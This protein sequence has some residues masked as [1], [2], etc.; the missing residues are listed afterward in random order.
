[1]NTPSRIIRNLGLGLV[2]GLTLIQAA[3]A[4]PETYGPR[5]TVRFEPLPAAVQNCTTTV[6][7]VW[8]GSA[9]RRGAVTVRN[10]TGVKTRKVTARIGPRNTIPVG[11]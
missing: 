4:A 10:C 7:Q 11:E 8:D 1:M 9:K 3:Q 5:G 6:R 2:A